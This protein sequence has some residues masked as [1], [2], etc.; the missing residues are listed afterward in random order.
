MTK[1]LNCDE[2]GPKVRAAECASGG[3]RG[4][5]PHFIYSVYVKEVGV[6]VQ[7]IFGVV[8]L[9]DGINTYITVVMKVETEITSKT[10]NLI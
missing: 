5:C 3:F 6:A 1:L 9:E 7:I 2:D 8:F 10:V 4:S